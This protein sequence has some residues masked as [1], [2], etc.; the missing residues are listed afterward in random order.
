MLIYEET[1][2]G[3][4]LAAADCLSTAVY[5]QDIHNLSTK[6]ELGKE[7]SLRFYNFFRKKC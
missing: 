7:K 2:V 4:W 5:P 3:K 6:A 1:V